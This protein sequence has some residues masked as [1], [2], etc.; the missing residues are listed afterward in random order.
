MLNAIGLVFT[1]A[2]TVEC[3]VKIMALGFVR[4]RRTYVDSLSVS[5]TCECSPVLCDVGGTGNRAGRNKSS[6]TSAYAP[7]PAPLPPPTVTWRT[8]MPR[9]SF[10]RYLAQTSNWLDFFVVVIGLGDFAGSDLGAFSALRL[11]RILRVLRAV[12]RFENLKQMVVVLISSVPIMASTFVTLCMVLLVFG[13][14]GVQLYQGELH[15]R[16]FNVDSGEL[17]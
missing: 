15:G 4:G 16:C 9:S 5:D 3:V 10:T 11:L 1:V 8:S 7:T 6:P 17:C 14:L 12:T 2:F 13:I